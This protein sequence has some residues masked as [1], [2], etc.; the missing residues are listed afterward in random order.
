MSA[1]I[2]ASRALRRAPAVPI[3]CM[4]AIGIGAGAATAMFAIVYG[5]LLRPLPFRDPDRLV[6]LTATAVDRTQ[7]FSLPEFDDW[8]ARASS[9][10]SL[11]QVTVTPVALTIGSQTV[12]VPGAVVSGHFFGTLGS[13]ALRGHVLGP[14]D[15]RTA[16]AVISERLWRE[17]FGGDPSAIGRALTIDN[18]VFTLAG[19][20]PARFGYPAQDVDVWMPIGQ[21]RPGAPPQWN[22][23][24]FRGFTIVARLRDGITL[25]AADADVASVARQL[26]A[27]FPRFN[28]DTS[29][30]VSAIGEAAVAPARRMLTILLGAVLLVLLTVCANVTNLLVARGVSRARETAVHLALGASRAQLAVQ[31]LIETGA[32]AFAG[33]VLALMIARGI[34]AIV[35][36]TMSDALPRLAEVR[37]DA[38]V[39]WFGALV[40]VAAALVSAALP[41]I[42]AW[43][44]P[45]AGALRET[46][47]GQSRR[48]RRSHLALVLLQ[49]STSYVLLVGMALLGRSFVALLR[50]DAGVEARGVSVAKVNMTASAFAAPVAQTAFLDGLLGRVSALPGV[51]SAGLISS[52]PPAGTQMRTTVSMPGL[53]GRDVQVEV[54]AVSPGTF[55]ALGIGVRRGRG[56][57][58]RD[59]AQAP[60]VVVL[61]EAAARQLFPDHDPIG[62]P[63]PFG[64][65]S[66]GSGVPIV[67]GLVSDVHYMGL[68]SGA[69]AAIYLPY[70]QRP[71]R[72]TNLIV[73][74]PATADAL[75][76]TL[77]RLAH[78]INPGVAIGS[79]RGWTDVVVD[80]AAPSRFRTVAL[81]LMA[82]LALIV[83]G[84]GLY[85][86][87]AYAVARRTREF[88]VRMAVGASRGTIVK[89]V[90]SEGLRTAAIGIAVG[91]AAAFGLARVLASMLFGI[92]VVDAPSFLLAVA[93]VG[94]T[95]LVASWLP[96]WRASRLAPAIALTVE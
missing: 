67:V 37:I 82:A 78:D 30:R 27:E 8:T 41:V 20:M 70:T 58:E 77:A 19:V 95:A 25:A 53:V 72:S 50:V 75:S 85:S 24:G 92:S 31:V 38:P 60:R 34:A 64:A 93:C 16:S 80:S 87:L 26:A 74:T 12:G 2:Q 1:F 71:F 42:H 69:G 88:A 73:R 10:E 44:T 48:A 40:L 28:R 59:S 32:I 18:D 17:R 43:R 39:I 45:P 36:N 91:A 63:L 56:F 6:Q 13:D 61:S 65:A 29:A 96:A 35:R 47:A 4:L 51:Q 66:G 23:R 21:A 15:D 7:N 68:A 52:L 83:S 76:S 54:V 3:A 94:V 86:V 55:A 22:M 57:S 5:V 89:M 79:P 14:D 81:M 46:R 33:G 9:F 62:Q 49:I 84:L 90:V 11:A